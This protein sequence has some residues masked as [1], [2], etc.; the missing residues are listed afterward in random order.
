MVRGLRGARLDH[1]RSRTRTDRVH[2]RLRPRPTDNRPERVRPCNPRSPPAA[3]GGR[4]RRAAADRSG[5]L[6]GRRSGR[7][8]RRRRERAERGAQ[9]DKTRVSRHRSR[10]QGRS[11][12]RRSRRQRE[13]PQWQTL[14][15]R[16]LRLPSPWPPQLED[17]R[18]DEFDPGETTKFLSVRPDGD[19][20][21]TASPSFE[22]GATPA[23]P[24]EF[25]RSTPL[26]PPPAT[27][28]SSLSRPTAPG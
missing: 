20:P 28:L 5:A 3:L 6:C 13:T 25:S 11:G 21:E 1:R 22:D 23:A 15:R 8:C 26:R 7:I 14:G 12:F 27:A 2:Q 18:D 10:R 4:R 16:A 17:P 9:T 24:L 19:E